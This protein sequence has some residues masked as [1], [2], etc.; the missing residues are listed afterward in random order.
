MDKVPEYIRKKYPV[1]D[2]IYIPWAWGQKV[3]DWE[4]EEGM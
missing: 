3:A 2:M 1:T 4:K